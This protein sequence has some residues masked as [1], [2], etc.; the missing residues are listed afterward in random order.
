[1]PLK[2]SCGRPKNSCNF[3]VVTSINVISTHLQQL[4]CELE[5]LVISFGDKIAG[6]ADTIAFHCLYPSLKELL[7]FSSSGRP[8]RVHTPPPCL[9][10]PILTVDPLGTED[11]RGESLGG[12]L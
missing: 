2:R 4:K 6:T 8:I 9:P 7:D 5:I 1:M 11:L 3:E 12:A 10:R